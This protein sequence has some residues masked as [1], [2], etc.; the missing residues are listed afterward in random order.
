MLPLFSTSKV[1]K[2]AATT[3]LPRLRTLNVQ[4]FSC[5]LIF[6]KSYTQ[7]EGYNWHLK[8]F[9]CFEC[10]KKLGGEQYVVRTHP[11]CLDCYNILFAKRCDT[12]GNIIAADDKR[13]S[14]EDHFWHATDTCFHCSNCLVSLVGKQFL[15][16]GKNAYCS[17][18]CYKGHQS[19]YIQSQSLT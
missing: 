13:L 19:Q 9:C 12:C 5:Q 8:H 15:P 3:S 1:L 11:Y 18:K 7:A 16:K 14:Y 10:D 4:F 17:A 2:V 6:S